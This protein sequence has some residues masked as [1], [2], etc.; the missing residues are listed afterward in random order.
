MNLECAPGFTGK[1]GLDQQKVTIAGRFC[2]RGF[3]RL[4]IDYSMI[5]KSYQQFFQL[6]IRSQQIPFGTFGEELC[7]LC[8]DT[9]ALVARPLQ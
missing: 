7:G 5:R 2:N 4:E 1:T 3:Y 9:K 6:L 8:I